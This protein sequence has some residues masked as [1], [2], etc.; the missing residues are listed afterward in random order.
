MSSDA[1]TDAERYPT[2]TEHGAQ[3]LEFLREHPS[4][5]IYRER[6]GNRLR[7]EEVAAAREFETMVAVAPPAWRRGERPVWLKDFVV[8]CLDDVP[9]YRRRGGADFEQLPTISRADLSHDIAAFVPD[10]VPI[11]RLINFRTSGTTG[12]PLLLAS[13]PTVAANYLAFHRK[14]LRRYG[15]ELRNGRGQVGVVLIGFQRKCFTYVSVNPTLDESGLAKI[16]LHPDDWR[17]PD[18][19]ARYLD[20][21]DAEVLTGDPLSFAE[22]LRLP[23]RTRPRAMLSTS[24]SLLPA[25]RRELETRFE[26]PVLD[27]YSM[28]EAGPVAVGIEGGHALLQHRMYVEIL[29]PD[30]RPVREGERGEIT[31]TGGFNAWLPLLRYRTG[32]FASLEWRDREWVLLGLEGRPPVTFRTASGEVLNNIEVTHRLQHLPL[33]QW[34]LHQERNGSVHLRWCGT[35]GIDGD[36]ERAIRE[37]FGGV[38]IS[39]ERVPGF[40]GKVVQYT[41]DSG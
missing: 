18:D 39:V 40:E 15:I 3:M 14:A 29:T 4:A 24:M 16:N 35:A 25:F 10:S 37:L 28:N 32:D 34:T 30:G 17:D 9:F 5:P 11:D 23:L 22:L 33:V 20:A 31:L 38:E 41:A 36:L 21:L 12:H 7:V 1:P 26:C 2:L 27:I 19:P 6:S 8:H 13:H